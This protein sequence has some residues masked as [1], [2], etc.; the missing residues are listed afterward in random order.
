MKL[1]QFVIGL[2]IFIIGILILVSPEF[3]Y[4]ISIILVIIGIVALLDA[5]Y[6]RER[7]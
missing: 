3:A 5:V 1:T 7:S 4:I 6:G 2:V